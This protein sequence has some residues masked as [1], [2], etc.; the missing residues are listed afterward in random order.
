MHFSRDR[1]QAVWRFVDAGY[2]HP[3]F[4]MAADEAIATIMEGEGA[5]PTVRVY[6][7]KPAAVSIGY[8]QRARETVNVEKCAQLG[9]PLVRRLTGGRAVF[10]D[11]EVTYSIVARRSY[12]GSRN[13]VLKTYRR[14]GQ[15]LISS[16]KQLGVHA[17]LVRMS[18]RGTGRETTHDLTPCFTSSGRY[19]VMV[20]G[21]K[22]VGSAQRWLGDVVLQH[23]SLLTGDGHLRI[24]QLLPEGDIGE[25]EKMAWELRNK[26]VSLGALLS[27]PVAYAEVADAL[28]CGFQEA[29]Q[30]L[31]EP[32]QLRP[33]EKSLARC[34]V[35]K[36]YGRQAWTLRK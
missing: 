22:V 36:R 21:R 16:L 9:I 11:E 26:T 10:H 7:W 2:A 12:L 20:D 4:N 17:H 32:G 25:G 5:F 24:V 14:I 13:S 23:G 30:V 8:S 35:K 27:R 33:E 19:E 1:G 29:F 6:G 28:F 3:F 34:L 31:L 18:P 15:A